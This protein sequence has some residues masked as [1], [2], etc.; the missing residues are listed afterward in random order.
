MFDVEPY[1][2]LCRDLVTSFVQFPKH[3]DVVIIQEPY[4]R[5]K[6]REVDGVAVPRLQIGGQKVKGGST[7]GIGRREG[8]GFYARHISDSLGVI[9]RRSY[10]ILCLKIEI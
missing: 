9:D 10:D 8:A 2:E 3:A 7:T 6:R 4:K 5:H 1:D